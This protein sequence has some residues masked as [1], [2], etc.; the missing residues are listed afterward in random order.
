MGVI[1]S[2]VAS[3][4]CGNK[5]AGGIV[6]C[7]GGGS[8]SG[9]DGDSSGGSSGGSGQGGMGGGKGEQSNSGGA[10][11]IIVANESEYIKMN[12][13]GLFKAGLEGERK[14]YH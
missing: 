14:W 5:R 3:A 1:V 2:A 7:D 9:C 11:A 4:G 8:G 13:K 12:E 10:N 6:G